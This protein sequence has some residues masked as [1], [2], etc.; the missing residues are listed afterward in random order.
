[1]NRQ[2]IVASS[3]TLIPKMSS[4]KKALFET[5]AI[6]P[7]TGIYRV[8]HTPHRLPHEVVILKGEH[9][10]RCAKCTTSVLFDLV[11][12]APDLFQHTVYRLYELP[13]TEEDTSATS[14]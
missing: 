6:V 9:F 4:G 11:H 12:A 14:A 3:V 7:E 10:P 13:V 8:T 1:M 5:G 2:T